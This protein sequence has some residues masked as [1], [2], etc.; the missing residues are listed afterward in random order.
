MLMFRFAKYETYETVLRTQKPVSRNT[1]FRETK[2]IF[3]WNTKVVSHEI[4]ENFEFWSQPIQGSM[5]H[6]FRNFYM[7]ISKP[8]SKKLLFKKKMALHK[9]YFLFRPSFTLKTLLYLLF[10]SFVRYKRNRCLILNFLCPLL[11][12]MINNCY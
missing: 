4:L 6:F 11:V 3:S 8:Y 5:I 12:I 1:K 10:R 9:R 7:N 2:H